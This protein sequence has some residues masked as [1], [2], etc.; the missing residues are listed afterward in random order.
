MKKKLIFAG[1]VLII[2]CLLTLSK[3]FLKSKKVEYTFNRPEQ[4]EYTV[5]KIE[6]RPDIIEKLVS[7][8]FQAVNERKIDTVV[9]HTSYDAIG[10]APYDV[11]GL[12]REYKS[13]QVAPHYLID[14]N[15]KIYQL[16][17]EK[18]IAY[19]AGKSQMPDGRQ[20]VN[21]FSIGIEL[22]NIKVGQ[23]TDEQ[24][25]ALN[26]LIKDIKSRY[27]IKY[28]LGHNQIASNRKDD[29]WNFD[30]DRIDK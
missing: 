12:I 11:D 22:M 7:W 21:E 25:Q 9:I 17:E 24:Y 28:V 29:P 13:Y 27:D 10:G 15:G 5:E 20:N 19:H 23:I 8:G 3:Y 16:V 2:L 14:R 18:D 6:A 1:V 30:W 4:Q 26:D